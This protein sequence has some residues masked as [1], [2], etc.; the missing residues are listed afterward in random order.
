MFE[1]AIGV[2]ASKFGSFRGTSFV[3]RRIPT[4][5]AHFSIDIYR[6]VVKELG[7]IWLTSI[8]IWCNLIGSNL[9]V[10]DFEDLRVLCVAYNF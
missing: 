7:T 4:R 1:C 3:L 6:L 8:V 2:F 5:V 10:S 9:F